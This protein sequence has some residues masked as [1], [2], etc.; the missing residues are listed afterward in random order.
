MCST[1]GLSTGS[2]TFLLSIHDICISSTYHVILCAHDAKVFHSDKNL[3]NLD[4]HLAWK[5]LISHVVRKLSH[6]MDIIKKASFFSTVIM[7]HYSIIYTYMQY[8]AI[9]I[10]IQV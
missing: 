4:E 9:T 5:V 6:S 10:L 8:T 2:T 7:L 1:T 3:N